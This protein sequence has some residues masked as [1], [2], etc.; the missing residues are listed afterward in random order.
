MD[1]VI[2]LLTGLLVIINPLANETKGQ[3]IGTW[4]SLVSALIG[5]ILLALQVFG[6]GQISTPTSTDTVGNAP[7]V[8]VV[9]VWDAGVD[10]TCGD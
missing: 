7:D 8:E 9:E 1:K 10:A 4:V 2:K 6:A 3:K 5:V